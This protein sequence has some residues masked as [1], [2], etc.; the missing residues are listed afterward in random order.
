MTILDL[1]DF[2]DVYY[3]SCAKLKELLQSVELLLASGFRLPGDT[4]F[5]YHHY[6]RLNGLDPISVSD[7]KA[8]LLVYESILYSSELTRLLNKCIMKKSLRDNEYGGQ[9]LMDH[10]HS[11]VDNNTDLQTDQPGVWQQAK[12]HVQRRHGVPHQC[13]GSLTGIEGLQ[14]T[15]NMACSMIFGSLAEKYRPIVFNGKSEGA[16]ISR[17][18]TPDVPQAFQEEQPITGYISPYDLNE[19]AKKLNVS[20]GPEM[21]C[22]CDPD[23]ICAPVCESDPT[24][25]CLCEENKLFTCIT[26]G[27]DIDDLDVPDLVQ[28]KRQ[29][30]EACGSSAASLIASTEAFPNLS[31]HPLH[32][33]AT[34]SHF[35]DHYGVM[36]EM[37]QQKQEQQNLTS[38]DVAIEDVASMSGILEFSEADDNSFWQGQDSTPLR[39]TSLSYRNALTQPFSKQCDYPPKRS[40][41]AQR[42]FSYRSSGVTGNKKISTFKQVAKGHAASGSTRKPLKQTNMRSLA[43]ISF[44]SLKLALRCDPQMHG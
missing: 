19:R 10:G 1:G 13:P 16:S 41:V 5:A 7:F 26:Q 33:A 34:E 4:Y 20:G 36:N 14:D 43:D 3:A 2:E 42:I 30:S 17:E 18:P 29:G 25:N 11:M 12:E 22:L 24:Q 27:I 31:I 21:P 37:E 15:R 6:E 32:H 44:T 23:C 9:K 39:V 8:S 35:S 40:S 28:R 38:N